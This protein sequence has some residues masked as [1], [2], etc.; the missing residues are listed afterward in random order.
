MSVVPDIDIGPTAC[1]QDLKDVPAATVEDMIQNQSAGLAAIMRAMG[2]DQCKSVTAAGLSFFPPYVLGATANIGCEQIAAIASS[3]NAAQNVLQCSLFS[4]SQSKETTATQ[5]L[6]INVTITKTIIEDCNIVIRQTSGIRVANYTALSSEV[7]EQMASTLDAALKG[8]IDSVQDQTKK[9]LFTQ[10]DGQKVVQSLTQNLNQLISQQSLTEVI[11]SQME[12]YE[13]QG[14]VTLV[15]DNAQMLSNYAPNQRDPT[16]P[17]LDVSQVFVLSV[18]SQSI[19]QSSLE[20]LFTGD[21]KADLLSALTNSQTVVVE[22]FTIPDIGITAIIVV[23]IIIAIVLLFPRRSGGGGNGDEKQSVLAGKVGIIFGGI[24]MA[25]GVI[26]LVAGIVL[27]VLDAAN[28]IF[29]YLLIAGG[30][31]LFIV[32]LVMLL[33]ARSQQLRFEQDLMIASQKK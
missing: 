23:V 29:C 16:K 18:L 24:L 8:F 25:V 21:A 12:R 26:V 4:S 19:L 3:A 14:E 20:K 9:G 31:I 17:C 30:A 27:L 32:G 6:K 13:N 1:A 15:L 11:Q 28:S 22:G 7:K 10:A 33:R 5:N 2:I